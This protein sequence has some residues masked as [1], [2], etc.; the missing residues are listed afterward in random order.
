MQRMP[1]VLGIA[2]LVGRHQPRAHRAER[3]ERLT[4]HELLV[5][6]LE[7]ARRNVVQ[8]RVAADVLECLRLVHAPAGAPDD[9]C[10]LGLEVDRLR[11]P[12]IP[13][14]FRAGA[15]HGSRELGEQN[16]VIGRIAAALARVLAVVHARGDD[17]SRPRDR[18]EELDLVERDTRIGG[19]FAARSLPCAVQV[20]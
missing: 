17:L 13:A 10:Q 20:G 9:D 11:Q 4:A 16:G 14:D 19:C 15:D 18:G 7:I 12:G 1:S 8:A 2:D 5:A 3:V 6:E